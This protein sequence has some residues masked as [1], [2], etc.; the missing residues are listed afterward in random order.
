MALAGRPDQPAVEVLEDRPKLAPDI[1][2][3]WIVGR[4][5]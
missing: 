5:W 4:Q 1:R 2:D 3:R